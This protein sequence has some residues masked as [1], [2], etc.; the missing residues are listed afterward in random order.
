MGGRLRNSYGTGRRG[1]L[2]VLFRLLKGLR[3]IRALS[4]SKSKEIEGGNVIGGV[5]RRKRAPVEFS[6]DGRGESVGFIDVEI[7][8]VRQSARICRKTGEVRYPGVLVIGV[9]QVRSAGFFPRPFAV[10]TCGSRS[11][12]VESDG[13][14]VLFQTFEKTVIPKHFFRGFP[15]C[16]RLRFRPSPV[17]QRS[18]YD[19]YVIVAGP[20]VFKRRTKR[21]F[22][23]NRAVEFAVVQLRT[24]RGY[25]V[26]RGKVE[27]VYGKHHFERVAFE[28]V[29]PRQIVHVPESAAEVGGMGSPR[30]PTAVHFVHGSEKHFDFQ[31]AGREEKPRILFVES[32]GGDFRG[33]ISERGNGNVVGTPGSEERHRPAEF[34]VGSSTVFVVNESDGGNL[35]SGVPKFDSEYLFR[36][37]VVGPKSGLDEGGRRGNRR[38][39]RGRRN[40]YE[41]ECEKR[42]RRISKKLR[43]PFGRLRKTIG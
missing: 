14:S 10:E 15:A 5:L 30:I 20:I 37:V 40:E 27:R 39:S 34:G 7:H 16:P 36:K 1:G 26:F 22:L 28:R 8:H 43:H 21:H 19:V 32:S 38:E 24:L 23:R 29:P 3:S 9:F 42:F 13:L 12:L 25:G 4:V 35:R 41:Q 11:Y 18:S 17:V 6:V 33:G 2:E 31:F